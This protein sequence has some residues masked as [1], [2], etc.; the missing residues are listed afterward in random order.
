[1]ENNQNCWAGCFPCSLLKL[2]KL[3]DIN[4]SSTFLAGVGIQ[5][6]GSSGAEEVHLSSLLGRFSAS[7]ILLGSYNP[8][9]HPANV[10]H[11]ENEISAVEEKAEDMVKDS[12]ALTSIGEANS[13]FFSRNEDTDENVS[14]KTSLTKISMSSFPSGFLPMMAFEVG[15]RS[16]IS[17]ITFEDLNPPSQMLVEILCEEQGFFL[18]IANSIRGLGLTILKG[19]MEARNDN[20]WA[21]LQ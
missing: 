13:D 21:R 16:M 6:A 4:H 8:E 19:V 11:T 9:Y 10:K 12:L 1:M 15:S 14:C 3:A 7:N 2:P 17:P 18:E 5:N 20:M